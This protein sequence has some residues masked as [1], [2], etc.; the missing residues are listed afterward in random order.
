M[1]VS[2]A[3]FVVE[4]AKGLAPSAS[5][6]L[7]CTAHE[8]VEEAEDDDDAAE[9]STVRGE[10]VR[11]AASFALRRSSSCAILHP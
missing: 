4:A 3:G 9:S 5:A 2:T 6:V 8:E 10:S 7:D 1:A 11:L